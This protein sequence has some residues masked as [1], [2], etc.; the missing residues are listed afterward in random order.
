MGV[1][2]LL[3]T[4]QI[5]HVQCIA[6]IVQELESRL[7]ECVEEGAGYEADVFNG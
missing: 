6:H 2:I 7:V 1:K 5:L 3:G 4:K